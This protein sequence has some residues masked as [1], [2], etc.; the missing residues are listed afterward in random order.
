MFQ[1]TGYPYR[2]HPCSGTTAS[3]TDALPRH[4]GCMPTCVTQSIACAVCRQVTAFRVPRHAGDAGVKDL[5]S[6]PAPPQRHTMDGWL[7]ECPAC[8]YVNGSIGTLLPGAVDIVRSSGYRAIG[9]ACG[10]PALVGRFRRHAQLVAAQP[11]AAGWAALHAAWV[12]D[13]IGLWELAIRCREDCD[14][15]WVRLGYGT[16]DASVRLRTISVDVLRRARY[17]EE[18]ERLIHQIVADGG[19]SPGRMKILRFQKHLISNCDLRV[20]TCHDVLARE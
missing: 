5:D 15:H 19:V 8:G 20:Y 6:R 4:H 3:Q 16:D 18:A 11:L 2:T 14:N 13:D 10:V 7:Q 1:A 12:C 17:F 9:A